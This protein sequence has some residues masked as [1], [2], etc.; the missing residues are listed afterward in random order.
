MSA[1]SPSVVGHAQEGEETGFDAV[2]APVNH[3]RRL[4]VVGA[5]AAA[6]LVSYFAVWRWLGLPLD[7]VGLVATLVG[8]WPYTPRNGPQC[9]LAY[10]DAG[11]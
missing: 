10:E 1:P 8:G 5:M 4:A 3:A 9:Q 11:A 2:L 6:A 7:L